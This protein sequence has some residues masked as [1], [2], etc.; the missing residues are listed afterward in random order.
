MSKINSSYFINI[1]N[2]R[3]FIHQITDK[4]NLQKEMITTC[5]V[6]YI[7]FDCTA[8][9]LHV[10]SLIQI[11]MLRWFQKTGNKPI[12]LMGG[13]TTKVG[14][15]SGKDSARPLLSSEKILF[16]KENIKIIF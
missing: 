13:G 14:D 4:E 2:E 6:G 5:T 15:P 9:S 11:M 8:P 7:G 10:G 12:V 16:N 1:M 3:G